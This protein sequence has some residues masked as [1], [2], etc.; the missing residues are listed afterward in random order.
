[1]PAKY[2]LTA[3]CLLAAVQPAFAEKCDEPVTQGDMTY[4]AQYQFQESDGQLNDVYARLRT[5]Y[6]GIVAAKT[7]LLTSQRAW[8]T[9]RDAECALTTVA[10]GG[11]SAEPMLRF[12]CL[13]Q[14]T[15]ERVRRLQ[16]RL[17]CQEGDLNC[18]AA[19]DAA[20]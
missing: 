16:D 3:A 7:G 14:L 8:L 9:Y 2:V 20:D 17:L 18:I 5:K 10:A 11:G 13:T 12:L 6:S 15:D 1:M 19:G 4:C